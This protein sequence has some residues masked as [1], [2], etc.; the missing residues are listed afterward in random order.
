MQ[1]VCSHPIAIHKQSNRN[2]APKVTSGFC[3][4]QQFDFK[5]KIQLEG[6]EETHVHGGGKG[7]GQAV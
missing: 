4:I 2:E 6:A 1:A 5:Y 7:E 3:S